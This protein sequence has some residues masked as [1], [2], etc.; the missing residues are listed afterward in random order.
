MLGE[1]L[2]ARLLWVIKMLVLPLGVLAQGGCENPA[3]SPPGITAVSN[4]SSELLVEIR[5]PGFELWDSSGSC[6]AQWQ[7]SQ[8]AGEPSFE[9]LQEYTDRVEGNSSLRIERIGSQPWGVV[10]Q[11]VDPKLLQGKR[12]RLSAKFKL[13]AVTELGG[14]IMVVTSGPGQVSAPVYSRYVQG[15][16]DWHTIEL[17]GDIPAFV[18]R[19]TLGVALEGGGTLM[20]DE[21]R[22]EILP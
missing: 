19:V 9:F 7:C 22:L 17:E 12:V 13:E 5:N 10:N 18:S 3:Q 4:V 20:V 14:G 21:V 6:P 15:T 8:H 16:R 11:L 1:N 2:G